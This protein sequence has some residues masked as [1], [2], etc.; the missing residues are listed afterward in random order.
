MAGMS[1]NIDFGEQETLT[2]G[3]RPDFVVRLP[4][5]GVIPID[6]KA[7][8]AH[9]LQAAELEAGSDQTELLKK[10]AKAMRGRIAELSQKRLPGNH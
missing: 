7:T 9:F 5:S 3:S 6:A 1:K 2:D 4:D 8:G 10:H